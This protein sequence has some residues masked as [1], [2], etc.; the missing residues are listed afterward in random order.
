VL[1]AFIHLYVFLTIALK[2][3]YLVLCLYSK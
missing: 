3:Y 1:S 2:K